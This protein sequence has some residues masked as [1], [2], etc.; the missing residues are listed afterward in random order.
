MNFSLNKN[1]KLC[2]FIC[3]IFI[4][5]GLFI[6]NYLKPTSSKNKNTNE[7]YEYPYYPYI[8]Q[9]EPEYIYSNDTNIRLM[10]SGD[11]LVWN[12]DPIHPLL[13]KCRNDNF[14]SDICKYIIGSQK[15]S[16][17]TP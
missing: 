17:T 12:T 3:V 7:K 2:I 9:S 4:I 10:G 1:F 16:P 13:I 8:Y 14:Q 5:I 11:L 15:I 6:A